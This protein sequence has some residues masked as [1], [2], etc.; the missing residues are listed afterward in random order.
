MR[1]IVT[2]AGETRVHLMPTE[3]KLRRKLEKEPAR[4]EH[5]IAEPGMGHRFEP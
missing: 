5:L 2:G 3:W 4:P 1:K